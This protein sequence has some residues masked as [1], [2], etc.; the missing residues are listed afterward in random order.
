MRIKYFD[1][2]NINLLKR[3]IILAGLFY[4]QFNFNYAAGQTYGLYFH[5]H[6]V[7]KDQRTSLDLSPGHFMNLGDNFDL[8]FQFTLN[9]YRGMYFGYIVRIIDSANKNLDLIYSFESPAKNGFEL[10]YGEDL[11]NISIPT[12]LSKLSSVW[13]E[14]KLSFDSDSNTIFFS[15]PDTSLLINDVHLS[16]K[17]KILF[18][19]SD[20]DHFI[21]NDVPPMSLKDIKI[22]KNGRVYAEWPLDEEA[23]TLVKSK[24]GNV[25]AKVKNPKWLS[26][27]YNS[28]QKLSEFTIEGNAE[29]AVNDED[30]TVYFIGDKK[31]IFF[32]AM[33][34]RFDSI[35]FN[36]SLSVLKAGGQAFYDANLNTIVLYNLDLKTTS[37]FDLSAN[38]WIETRSNYYPLT[39]F[40]HHNNYY[41]S[42][43]STLYTFGGYGQHEYK[44][45][46]QRLRLNGNK[47][48]TI[49]PNGMAYSPRY[50]AASGNINDSIYFIGGYGS[51][52][53]KQILN[54]QNFY[55]M[56]C[57]SIKE[58]KFNK[59]YSFDPP[60]ED[61]AFGNSM[62]IN[63]DTREFWALAFPNFRYE[64]YL[65]LYKGSLDAE[66]L[67]PVG[68][69]IPYYFH[70]IISF[71]DLFYFEKAKNLYA[72]T[73]LYNEKHFTTIAIHSIGFPPNKNHEKEIKKSN[74]GIII[75]MLSGCL[76]II[77][78]GFYRFRSK[79]RKIA[80]EMPIAINTDRLL[81]NWQ[82]SKTS[83][84][85]VK[86]FFF[87]GF[88]V[89]NKRGEDITQKFSPLVKELFLLIWLHSIS[90][91]GISS[92][93]LIEI[94]WFGKDERSARN[95]LAVNIAKLKKINGEL[96]YLNL[97]QTNKY[98]KYTFDT[99]K[100]FND[101]WQC[102]S[103]IKSFNKGH[104]DLNQ[105]IPLIEVSNK[106][107]FLENCSY[108]WLDEFKG[109]ISNMIIDTLLLFAGKIDIN[110]NSNLLIQLAETILHFDE[111]NEEAVKIKCK[112][113]TY[114][115]KHALAKE[116][117]AQFSTLYK[118]LYD[119]EFPMTFSEMLSSKG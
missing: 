59:I 54:P 41:S 17:V 32:S 67:S 38:K 12:E 102:F 112:S 14:I 69:K 110:E 16:G 95:N 116:F 6:N 43:D 93:L 81:D 15:T 80:K 111:M 35:S 79:K 88:Q 71:S 51:V 90:N 68:N 4:Y 106:G 105:V 40:W 107:H 20:L 10:V 13:N 21:T 44:N 73:T 113:L 99:D 50:L 26:V 85:A 70:D 108:G 101:Y 3:A 109:R 62:I 19:A 60:D 23:G 1:A 42:E 76:F 30:E 18:G 72:V 11:S 31:L 9:E 27:Q 91:K 83:S 53:G 46:I 63:H 61:I 119:E 56:W 2:F 22:L 103:L 97:S 66:G 89:I 82:S 57:Y 28:W 64:S 34:Q 33:E 86:I 7:L 48:D 65:Q 37:T 87:G 74:S 49:Q 75:A 94:L 8:S 117:F 52:T 39:I 24:F 29:I 92:E 55:D 100:V 45:V 36:D 58:N 78:F 98:W 25:K 115:G 104:I 77:A 96:E 114:Q 84:Y 47:W 118:T 5:S